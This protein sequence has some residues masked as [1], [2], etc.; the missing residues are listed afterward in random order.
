MTLYEQLL[1]GL[2]HLLQR[3]SSEHWEQQI[4]SDLEAWRERRDARQHRSKYGGNST[5]SD[6]IISSQNK[7][8]VDDLQS[9]WANHLRHQMQLALRALSEKPEDE[10]AETKILRSWER[11]RSAFS[12]SK[13]EGTSS[14]HSA[15]GSDSRLRVVSCHSCGQKQVSVTSLENFVADDLIQG[16]LYG[17]CVSGDIKALVDRLMDKQQDGVAEARSE[18]TRAA[19]SAGIVVVE[20]CGPRT[21]TCAACNSENIS[22]SFWYLTNEGGWTFAPPEL[23]RSRADEAQ[24][25]AA[26]SVHGS[27]D[28]T[29]TNR[30]FGLATVVFAFGTMVL[31][32][33]YLGR[34][35]FP[36]ATNSIRANW[37]LLLLIGLPLVVLIG[38]VLTTVSGVG[39]RDYAS[40]FAR[41]TLVKRIGVSVASIALAMLAILLASSIG[42][43]LR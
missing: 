11:R 33:R 31:V 15:S 23:E 40:V 19:E 7:H 36:D 32:S 39:I 43:A 2:R 8:T 30:L 42:Q 35:G 26:E 34:H 21:E 5:Y 20:D 12:R 14:R 27:T 29:V 4:Q 38:G 10:R 13:P 3:V 37:G 18:V 22:V 17:A 1:I 25:P 24:K 28:R 6:W 41:Q 16:F 9:V